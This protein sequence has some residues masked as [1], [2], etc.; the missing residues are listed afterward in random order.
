MY[1]TDWVRTV[2]TAIYHYC[3]TE[4][5]RELWQITLRNCFNIYL[6]KTLGAT[7]AGMLIFD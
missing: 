5:Y 1:E 4:G 6:V 2:Q 3:G 7:Y